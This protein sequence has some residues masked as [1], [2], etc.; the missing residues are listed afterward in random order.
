[1][2]LR[3]L[4]R[5]TARCRSRTAKMHE[6]DRSDRASA[7]DPSKSQGAHKP[8]ICGEG[9][10]TASLAR[11]LQPVG[12]M[13]K[14]A[15]VMGQDFEDSEFRE[16]FDALIEAGYQID[17]VGARAGEVV[18]GKGR[19][20]SATVEVAASAANPDD[21]KALV[22][23]GGYSPDHLRTDQGVVDFL[24]KFARTGKLM[25]AICHGP[26]LLIEADAVEGKQLTSWPSC[27]KDL[28]NA[29]A[30]WV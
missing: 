27:R 28:E 25:A 30:R 6:R 5:A 26:Q 24:A 22:I 3:G 18:H 14:I 29:R 8:D 10:S 13:T 16:P 19:H 2:C 15:F 20:E 23:P 21:Y 17:V 12:L 11:A 1:M 9:G 4:R 7:L